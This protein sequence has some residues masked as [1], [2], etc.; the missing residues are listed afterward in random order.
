[1]SVE[2][3]EVRS[4]VTSIAEV[5]ARMEEIEAGSAARDGVACFNR[6]Y[7]EVTRMVDDRISQGFFA[8]MNFLTRLDVDFA[9]LYFQAVDAASDPANVPL[10]WRPLVE[11][12][13]DMQIEPIQFALAGMNAHINHDLPVAV[14]KTCGDLGTD[15]SAGSHQEDYQKVDLLLDATVQRV[16]ES[17]ESSAELSVDQHL[18]AVANLAG[19]WAINTA[20]DVAWNNAVVLW[21][22]R[23]EPGARDLFQQGLASTAAAAS[24]L[25]LTPV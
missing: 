22:L 15:P 4:P 25:L 16:R 8:D 24:R 14:V 10:A 11:A 3:Q 17:F 7:L 2:S 19:G 20:R 23:A 21:G 1:M 13:S 18:R 5:I 9:N 6:M 12:R